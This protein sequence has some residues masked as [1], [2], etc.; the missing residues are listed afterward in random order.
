MHCNARS[1]PLLS[2]QREVLEPHR[3][4]D[5]LWEPSSKVLPGDWREDLPSQTLLS[6]QKPFGANGLGICVGFDLRETVAVAMHVLSSYS[7]RPK[8]RSKGWPK[9]ERRGHGKRIVSHS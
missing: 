9:F 6:N 2:N 7:R 1:V 5:A 8:C 4:P 3:S